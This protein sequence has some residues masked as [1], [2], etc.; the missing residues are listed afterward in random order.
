MNN[1]KLERHERGMKK[2]LKRRLKSEVVDPEVCQGFA[3]DK[4]KAALLNINPTKEAT[5]D[6]IHPRFLH[7]L[8]PDSISLLTSISTNRGRIPKSHKYGE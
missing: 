2:G 6:K 1:L 7:H 3:T 5:P 8:G 4:V